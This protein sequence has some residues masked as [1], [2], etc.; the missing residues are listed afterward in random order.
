MKY[1][2]SKREDSRVH[3]D[4]IILIWNFIKAHANADILHLPTSYPIIL[5]IKSLKSLILE[6]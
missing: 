6:T 1:E 3:W 4:S 5:K 2:I